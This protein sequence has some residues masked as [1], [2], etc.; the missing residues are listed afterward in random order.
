MIGSIDVTEGTAKKTSSFEAKCKL[1]FARDLTQADKITSKSKRGTIDHAS[2]MVEVN[3]E[4]AAPSDPDCEKCKQF[5]QA[6]CIIHGILCKICSER[7][8][9]MCNKM[10]LKHLRDGGSIADAGGKGG[11]GKGG[12]GRGTGRYQGGGRG[13]SVNPAKGLKK[14]RKQNTKLRKTHE[15]KLPRLQKALTEL[16][17]LM[18]QI[19]SRWMQR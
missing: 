6:Y 13:D 1:L 7:G 18:A 12:R 19:S 16:M 11:K 14:V 15:G 2:A 5:G 9:C 3:D 17:A 4:D 10:V 8:R